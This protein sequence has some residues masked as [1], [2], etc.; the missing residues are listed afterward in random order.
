MESDHTNRERA[1]CI[2]KKSEPENN[3]VV[4]PVEAIK[5]GSSNHHPA[6]GCNQRRVYF[7]VIRRQG[8]GERTPTATNLHFAGIEEIDTKNLIFFL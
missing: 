7:P 3:S 1:D 8:P 5:V 4:R 6:F 2:Q